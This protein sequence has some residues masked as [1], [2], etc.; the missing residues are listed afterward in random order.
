[1]KKYAK[2]SDN[3]KDTKDTLQNNYKVSCNIFIIMKSLLK[4]NKKNYKNIKFVIFFY[5]QKDKHKLLYKHKLY[6][7]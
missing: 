1:M 4:K 3:L 2:I 5:K 6:I 7:L